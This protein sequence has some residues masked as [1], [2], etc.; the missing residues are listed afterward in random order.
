MT[1]LLTLLLTLGVVVIAMWVFIRVGTPVYRI[2]RDNIITLLELVLSGAATE[3]DWYV[4][5]GIPLRHN[6]EL[7]DVQKRC[8]ELTETEFTG[9]Q[10]DKL[11]T[12]KGLAELERL[13]VSLKPDVASEFEKDGNNNN[14]K[15]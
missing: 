4:F 14:E 13:L 12:A 7:R 11:F 2:E 5:I 8:E 6:S 9:I 10:G 3:N 15:E 1:Y